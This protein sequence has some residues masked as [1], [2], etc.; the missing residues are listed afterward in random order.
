ML[1]TAIIGAAKRKVRKHTWDAEGRGGAGHDGDGVDV[2]QCRC[3]SP[4]SERGRYGS[5]AGQ[6]GAQGNNKTTIFVPVAL[7]L[8]VPASVPDTPSR[9]RCPTAV[10]AEPWAEQV[11]SGSPDRTACAHPNVCACNKVDLLRHRIGDRSFLCGP[12]VP[13]RPCSMH[14]GSTLWNWI[15]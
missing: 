12:K 11:A 10:G 2:A 14:S 9:P 1:T 7:R 4:E 13:S 8:I 5:A 3:H 15:G 6:G